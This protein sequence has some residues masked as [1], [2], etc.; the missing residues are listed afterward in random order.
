MAPGEWLGGGLLG[1]HL[2]SL[3]P[4]N[5]DDCLCLYIPMETTLQ[6]ERNLQVNRNAVTIGDKMFIRNLYGYRASERIPKRPVTMVLL[7]HNHYFVVTFDTI[8][9]KGYVYGRS[10]LNGVDSSMSDEDIECSR[11]VLVG[12]D[13]WEEWKG[14]MYWKAVHELLD[15]ECE[16]SEK[17]TVF[18]LEWF[19]VSEKECVYENELMELN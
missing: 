11:N 9:R 7:L 2:L 12:K 3:L 16:S 17:V 4:E 13:N 10:S 6:I 18:S 1:F 15:W 19:A 8:K 5:L 14:P